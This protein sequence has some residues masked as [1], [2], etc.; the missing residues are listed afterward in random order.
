MIFISNL[1]RGSEKF[2]FSVDGEKV[3]SICS[4]WFKNWGISVKS[5]GWIALDIDGTITVEKHSVPEEVVL[6]LKNLEAEGWKIALATGRPFAFAQ[7]ALSKFDFPFTL[8][9]QNGS[10]A[11]EMPE[12]K[13]LFKSYIPMESFAE[14][15]K[16]YE[17]IASDY[18]IYSGFESGDF[19]FWR[20]KRFSPE[21][22]AYLEDL[23]TRQKG[24]WQQI[25][26]VSQTG[27]SQFPLIK[28]FGSLDR[29]LLLQKRLEKSASFE[30][31]KIRDPFDP[32]THMLLVTD[33]LASK[34]KSLSKVFELLGR[35][36]KVI[37]AGDDENDLSLLEIADVKIAMEHAP[38]SLQQ[39]AHFIA[40]PTKDLGIINA[41]EFAI[42]RN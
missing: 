31:A 19:C 14:V 32:K 29:I 21:D 41:L 30:I 36:E 6:F 10:L 3:Y 8:L 9:A 27:L 16:A 35:G 17:G 1:H 7:L 12:K 33:R 25:E 15:E 22:L 4:E 24:E 42:Q 28:C 39:K 38:E 20:P 23:Q 5:K 13:V 40:P 18:L 2:S 11:L 37:A 34:G 26:S